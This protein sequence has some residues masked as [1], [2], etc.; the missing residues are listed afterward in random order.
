MS[1]G[2]SA[3]ILISGPNIRIMCSSGSWGRAQQG[4]WLLPLYSDMLRMLK[5]WTM[6]TPTAND[7]TSSFR[8]WI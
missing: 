5:V 2:I 6:F 1:A 4:I 3:A 7:A 8:H